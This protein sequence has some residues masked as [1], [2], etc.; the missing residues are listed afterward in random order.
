MFRVNY[1]KLCTKHSESDLNYSKK[2]KNLR[3]AC[4]FTDIFNYTETCQLHG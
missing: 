2:Y 3:I 1:Q 4:D